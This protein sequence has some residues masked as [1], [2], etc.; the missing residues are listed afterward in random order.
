MFRRAEAG[1]SQLCRQHA[2]A[3]GEPGLQRL[4]H[5]AEALLEPGRLRR[6]NRH[7]AGRR[8]RILPQQP[9]RRRRGANAAETAGRVPSALV[10]GRIHDATEH[11][12]DLEADAIGVE[13]C[14]TAGV[15][16]LG[17]RQ[18]GRDQW[19][20][21]MRHGH[22]A[23]VIEVQGVSGGAVGESRPAGAGPLARTQHSAPGRAALGP[24]HV[25]HQPRGRLYRPGQGNPDGVEH[26]VARRHPGR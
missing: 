10:V 8:P 11:R 7:A 3:T 1:V 12:L 25:A 18:P 17:H 19:R 16:E 4:H 2:I 14:G 9:G 23:H 26:G 6:G 13:Q 15:G 5:G 22:E 21:R 20:A 24:S